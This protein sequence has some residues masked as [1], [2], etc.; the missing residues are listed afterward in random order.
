MI[1]QN[2]IRLQLIKRDIKLLNQIV[3]SQNCIVSQCTK[4]ALYD[5]NTNDIKCLFTDPSMASIYLSLI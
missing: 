1:N 4:N 2:L 3:N 5:S